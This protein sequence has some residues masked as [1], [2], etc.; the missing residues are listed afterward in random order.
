M[1]LRVCNLYSPDSYLAIDCVRRP[2][3]KA[4]RNPSGYMM[5]TQRGYDHVGLHAFFPAPRGAKTHGT[6]N[7][8]P[9][10]KRL[11]LPSD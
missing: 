1:E 9:V 4:D 10:P 8:G 2:V 3:P 5:S 7:R 6:L 11:I